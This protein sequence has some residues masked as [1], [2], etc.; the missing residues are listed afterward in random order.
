MG[1]YEEKRDGVTRRLLDKYGA[2]VYLR[3][4]SGEIFDAEAGEVT[5]GAT[6]SYRAKA[7][8]LSKQ[9]DERRDVSVKND[10]LTLFLGAYGLKT[11]PT[12]SDHI[13]LGGRE[14]DIVAVKPVAPGGVNVAYEIRMREP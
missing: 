9:R 5:G 11:T 2:T 8:I 4:T 7:L 3:V 6:K 13:Q 1:F 10:D 14:Y 12:T